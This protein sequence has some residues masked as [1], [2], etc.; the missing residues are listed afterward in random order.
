MFSAFK[1]SSDDDMIKRCPSV[2]G[3]IFE[4]EFLTHTE[5][6]ILTVSAINEEETKP[7]TF[8][9]CINPA[10]CQ[11]QDA[12]SSL[13]PSCLHCLRPGHRAIDAVCLTAETG[14]GENYLLLIQV[15]LSN[16]ANHKSKALD[17]NSKV[18]SVENEVCKNDDVKSIGEYYRTL[19]GVKVESK[20]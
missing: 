4:H 14:S 9:F 17:I 6:R 3:L 19:P 2:R 1:T 8:S 18:V 12:L 5:L 13:S 16:Y 15:S 10:Y 7:R 11:M 20:M